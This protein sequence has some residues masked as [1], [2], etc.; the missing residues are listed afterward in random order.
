MSSLTFAEIKKNAED[1][2]GDFDAGYIPP[3]HIRT[4]H[5][6]GS[7]ADPNGNF[8]IENMLADDALNK[9]ALANV[10]FDDGENFTV[11]IFTRRIFTNITYSRSHRIDKNVT[12][13]SIVKRKTTN[14]IRYFGSMD[15]M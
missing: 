9:K 12:M 2:Y 14:E 8:T 1:N 13:R 3:G 15:L 4:I 5:R 6:S 7:R 11:L 10:D